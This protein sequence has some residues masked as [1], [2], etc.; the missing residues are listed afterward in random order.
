MTA[1]T[2]VT[3]LAIL[4]VGASD[5]DAAVIPVTTTSQRV[6]G[7]TGCSLQEAIYSANFD[8][9]V[10]ISGYTST[11]TTVVVRTE[12]VPGSG[13]D[14]IVLPAGAALN[15]VK[16]VDDADNP[17]GPTAT[18]II[19]SNITI[20]AHGATLQRTGS[21]NFR[22]FAV[23]STGHLTIRRAYIRGFRAQGGNGG[24]GG[25][26]GMGAGGSI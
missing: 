26:G 22:L 24:R 19:T 8:D 16:V 10:A 15:L 23:G 2:Y 7:G 9:N 6:S 11:G 1:T 3:L 18:P 21:A 25:G 13:D 17:A 12:C 5:A 20:L 14:V 4:I